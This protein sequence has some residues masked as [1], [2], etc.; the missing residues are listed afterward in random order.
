MVYGF[1]EV[2]SQFSIL[3]RAA[4]TL[5]GLDVLSR[6][7]K[8]HGNDMEMKVLCQAMYLPKQMSKRIIIIYLQKYENL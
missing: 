1:T 3:N 5:V 6:P 8:Q 7:R 4:I 2:S